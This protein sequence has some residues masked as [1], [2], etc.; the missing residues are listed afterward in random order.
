[1]PSSAIVTVAGSGTPLGGGG[2]ETMIGGGGDG[3][4]TMIGGGGGGGTNGGG[5][6]GGTTVTGGDV[7]HTG[8]KNALAVGAQMPNGSVVSVTVTAGIY[9]FSL[10]LNW[11]RRDISTPSVI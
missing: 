2:G 7:P 11:P 6:T 10:L 8:G 4:T 1:M 3:G 5:A 9:F